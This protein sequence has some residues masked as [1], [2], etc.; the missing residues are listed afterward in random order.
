M[1]NRTLTFT[2][3]R[4]TKTTARYREDLKFEGAGSQ[5]LPPAIGIL[6]LQK[7]LVGQEPPMTLTVTIAPAED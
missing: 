3:E 2:L 1:E 4:E 6:H 5:G 7:W